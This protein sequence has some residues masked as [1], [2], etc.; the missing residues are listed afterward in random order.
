MLASLTDELGEFPGGRPEQSRRHVLVLQ[1]LSPN[2]AHIEKALEASTAAI[3]HV[4][5]TLIWSARG[6]S[7]AQQLVASMKPLGV[8][9][10][11]AP[12]NSACSDTEMRVVDVFDD[13]QPLTCWNS[14]VLPGCATQ[15][16]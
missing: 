3:L 12:S 10:T 15:H 2:T 9:R 11:A 1:S 4:A 14:W 13:C 7:D 5:F 6:G 16:L 8:L